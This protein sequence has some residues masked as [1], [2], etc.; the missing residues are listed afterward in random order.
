VLDI[1][2]S[3]ITPG[4]DYVAQNVDGYVYAF[5]SRPFFYNGVWNGESAVLR[6][7]LPTEADYTTRVY[8]RPAAPAQ[9]STDIV[10]PLLLT[11]PAA[12]NAAV[13]G[14]SFG[15]LPRNLQ[16][17]LFNVWLEGVHKLECN[18]P[19]RD[20]W[21]KNLVY[22]VRV[23]EPKT[24]PSIDWAQ[25]A[26]TLKFLARDQSG[27]AWAYAGRP[28]I[29]DGRQYWLSTGDCYQVDA[30]FTSYNPGDCEW[31]DSLVERPA[32]EYTPADCC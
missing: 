15:E 10:S 7:H 1:D 20:G 23:V 21:F 13:A 12:I 28:N 17:A 32:V 6:D 9:W 25:V 4:R 3:R 31:Q 24:K 26:P 27:R 30:C 8:E 14:R 16:L 2:W 29:E 11:D 19:D 22:T 18:A 5:A